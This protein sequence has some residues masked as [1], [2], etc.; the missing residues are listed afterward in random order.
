MDVLKHRLNPAC[1]ILTSEEIEQLL[2][3]FKC[4]KEDLPKIK[5]SDP[6]A[7][8]LK[9]KIGDVIEFDRVSHTAGTAKY[10]RVVV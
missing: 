2:A 8:A 10:Y 7:Q 3:K 5:S 6:L 9:A 4:K 1:R